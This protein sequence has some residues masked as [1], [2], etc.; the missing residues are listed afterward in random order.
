VLQ[1]LLQS[2]SK[3]KSKETPTRIEYE[4]NGASGQIEP[5]LRL[6]VDPPT[7]SHVEEVEEDG[8]ESELSPESQTSLLWV[9][10]RH[11]D[12]PD[13]AAAANIK[14]QMVNFGGKSKVEIVVPLVSDSAFFQLLVATLEGLSEH[15]LAIHAQF[16]ETLTE[17]TRAVSD[18]A[19]PVSST[20]QGFKG[21]SPLKA[22]P[23]GVRVG[24]SS[25]KSDLYSWREIFQLYVETEVF[26]SVSER[27][28]GEHT[29]EECETR[30]KQF[31]ERLTAR[32]LGDSRKLRLPQSRQALESFLQIN[33][34]IL[35]VKKLELANAEAIRK[36]LKKH[37]K[38]TAPPSTDSSNTAQLALLPARTQSLSRILVQELGTTLLPIIPS[39]EDYACLICTSIAFKPIRLS[40]GH[41]FCVRCLVK[42][43]KRGSAACP[44][45]RAPCVLLAD[46]SNVDWALLNFMCDWFPEESALK[47]RQNEKEATREQFEELGLDP[48]DKCTLM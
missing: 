39:L 13:V 38:R 7:G 48:D 1:D 29:V 5:R 20:S 37:T 25:T 4:L 8:M 32:G 3:G 19:R 17:L 18:S 35:N 40:C 22:D 44:M 2:S 26:E 28:R 30:L 14:T 24:A 11:M 43:Q 46:G 21:H 9:L 42:M 12:P 34:F 23:G 6:W 16:V 47:L 10:Q 27:A 36:I 31:A 41:L 15:L 33:F 45:C